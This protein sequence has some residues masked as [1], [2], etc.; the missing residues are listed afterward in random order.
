MKRMIVSVILMIILLGPGLTAQDTDTDAAAADVQRGFALLDQL[1][2]SFHYVADQVI[3]TVVQLDVVD[4]VQVPAVTGPFEY[5][6]GQNLHQENGSRELRQTGLGSGVMISQR[7]K[8]VTVLTNAH[9][10]GEADEISVRLWDGRRFIGTLVGSD[11]RKDVALVTFESDEELPVARLGNSDGLRVGD[12]VLAIGN[13]L[14]FSSTMTS[15]IISA[16]GR[17]TGPNQGSTSFTD[18][19]Q[20]DAAINRGN[21]GGPLVNLR[22]EVVGINT[23]IASPSGGSVGIGFAVPINSITGT[24]EQLSETGRV[25]YGWLGAYVS[26]GLQQPGAFISNIF[27]DSPAD[28]GDLLPGDLVTE[29]NGAAVSGADDLI[30]IVGNSR[31]GSRLR[32]TVLRGGEQR[33]LSVRLQNRESDE[34]RDNTRVWPGF[35]SSEDNEGQMR[36][37][38]VLEGSPAAVSGFRNGDAIISINGV[39]IED[40]ESLSRA[41]AES[42][43]NSEQRFRLER[44][45]V[46]FVI[47]LEKQ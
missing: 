23:W 25:E 27:I 30:R 2:D 22:G 8:T 10:V 36:I 38:G 41:F 44:D 20:T 12:W 3:P 15:G 46:Q 40:Q 33:S 18:Y 47:G 45:G 13:P 39:E 11:E 17:R 29:I 31:P 21:S 34:E 7:G 28:R 1:E 32:M 9:V 24:I 37:A 6:F 26:D 16:T 19:I 14:G 43:G 5:F 35:I 4:V 42:R